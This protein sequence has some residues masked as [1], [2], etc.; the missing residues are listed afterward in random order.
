MTAA[1]NGRIVLLV[2]TAFRYLEPGAVPSSAAPAPQA[3]PPSATP[4]QP[5]A[6]SVDQRLQHLLELRDKG[7]ITPEDF[8]RRKAELLKEI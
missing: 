6:P 4:A 5:S 8:E 2:A 7:L 3:P 1:Q